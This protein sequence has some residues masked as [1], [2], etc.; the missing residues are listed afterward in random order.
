VLSP[1]APVTV[2]GGEYVIDGEVIVMDSRYIGRSAGKVVVKTM[3]L[4]SRFALKFDVGM[5]A[6]EAPD[7][8]LDGKSR[9]ELNGL[10]RALEG[11]VA[12]EEGFDWALK[13]EL[14]VGLT[15]ATEEAFGVPLTTAAAD[16][17]RGELD[18][19]V[20]D[21]GGALAGRLSALIISAAFVELSVE[22]FLA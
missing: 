14:A 22:V 10:E 18:D 12:A 11:R 2:V 1:A 15:D 6:E 9:V 21:A 4:G 17:S 7:E 8:T 19:E 13:D 20:G 16:D 5:T 3:T